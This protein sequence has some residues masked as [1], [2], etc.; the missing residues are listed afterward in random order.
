M[1][2]KDTMPSPDGAGGVMPSP[3]PSPPTATG[4]DATWARLE[5]QLEWYDRKST[6]AQHA[7][8]RIKVVELALATAIPPLAAID[9]G[10]AAVTILGSVVVFLEGV[11]HLFQYHD[12][13]INYR[14]TCEALKHERYLFLA[15]AGP[16]A[17]VADVS[18]LLAERVEGLVSQEHATWATTQQQPAAPPATTGR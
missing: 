6:K 5:E 12:Q 11:L 14:S 1:A 13:W 15:K 9:I 3:A 7:Y 8:K 18:A 17:N 10:P 16:Y 4:S 2:E